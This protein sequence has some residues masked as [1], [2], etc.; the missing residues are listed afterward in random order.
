MI[1]GK[2]ALGGLLMVGA[3]GTV[4]LSAAV[5]MDQRDLAEC[6][7]TYSA[8]TAEAIKVRSAANEE[9][10]AAQDDMW[11]AV[12]TAKS[13]QQATEVFDRYLSARARY[14]EQLRTH[15]LPDPPTVRECRQGQ[16]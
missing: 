13:R 8:A 7:A 14:R 11:R 10:W 4:G 1:S 12:R 5:S 9:Q 16:P 2:R 6:I 3:L 15:P